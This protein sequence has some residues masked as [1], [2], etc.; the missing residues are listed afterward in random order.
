MMDDMPVFVKVEDYKDALDVMNMI[1]LKIEDAKKTL[2]K[3]QELK[4]EEDTE[5]ELWHTT[6]EE[7][8]R[9]VE[10]IDKTLSEPGSM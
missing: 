9:K 4:S 10:F 3:I 6:L 5:L 2:E 8:E 1:R 7:V